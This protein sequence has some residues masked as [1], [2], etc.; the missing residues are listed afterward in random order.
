MK[1]YMIGLLALILC[2]IMI[3]PA[4]AYDLPDS[5]LRYT[6]ITDLFWDFDIDTDT[7]L[8]QTQ[9]SIEICDGDSCE[10]VATIQR[11]VNNRWRDYKTFRIK[12][13]DDHA[14]L[15]KSWTVPSGYVYRC[16]YIFNVYEG[17]SIVETSIK[18]SPEVDYA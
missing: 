2:L 3:V 4:S 6:Y 12:R 16:H 9:G 1:K 5:A 15:N 8:S 18:N 11:K 14:I 17:N 10:V 7:G 13:Q